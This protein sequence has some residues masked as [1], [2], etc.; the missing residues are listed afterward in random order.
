MQYIN[1]TIFICQAN[2]RS[3]LETSENY[4]MLIRSC[5]T[6]GANEARK[7]KHKC[8]TIVL[9]SKWEFH[10][11]PVANIQLPCPNSDSFRLYSQ[12]LSGS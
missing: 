2:K 3:E 4:L 6:L 5:L 1:N 10:K 11:F 12:T 9:L 7:A 8:T